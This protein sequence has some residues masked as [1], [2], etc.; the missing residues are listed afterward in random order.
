MGALRV[1]AQGTASPGEGS[2]QSPRIGEHFRRGVERTNDRTRNHARA[3]HGRSRDGKCQLDQAR[4]APLTG[5]IW[6]QSGAGGH[7]TTT[8]TLELSKATLAG[9]SCPEKK[10]GPL[11]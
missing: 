7:E 8:G 3:Q 11:T 6:Q 5:T 1:I 4:S 9:R 2:G 10:K